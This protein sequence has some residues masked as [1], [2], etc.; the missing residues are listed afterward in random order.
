[1][2]EL[3]DENGSRVKLDIYWPEEEQIA[4]LR[5]C[6]ETADTPYIEDTLLEET[7]YEAGTEYICGNISL[8]EAVSEIEKKL[9][10]FMAE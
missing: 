4:R 10:I 7:V 9:A 2:L 1:M 8:E 5:N 6:I 3:P